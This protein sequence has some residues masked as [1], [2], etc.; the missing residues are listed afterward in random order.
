MAECGASKVRPVH[1]DKRLKPFRALLVHGIFP[2]ESTP[3]QSG[4]MRRSIPRAVR[5]SRERVGLSVN[6]ATMRQV[7]P[8]IETNGEFVASN[9]S[10]QGRY[11]AAAVSFGDHAD[12]HTGPYTDAANIFATNSGTI[13]VALPYIPS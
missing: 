9:V 11:Q 5:A 12:V 2:L 8:L 13:R 10:D 4:Q 6:N 7:H 3:S 1:A